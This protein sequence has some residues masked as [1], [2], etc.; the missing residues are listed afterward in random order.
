M[1]KRMPEQTLLNLLEERTRYLSLLKEVYLKKQHF[2]IEPD[3]IEMERLNELHEI[4]LK[5]MLHLEEKWHNYI[6]KLKLANNL[7]TET[8]DVILS[9]ILD[10]EMITRYFAYKDKMYQL[11]N[12]I[13]RIKKNSLLMSKNA[14]PFIEKK[15]RSHKSNFIRL[16]SHTAKPAAIED[17][18]QNHRYGKNKTHPFSRLSGNFPKNFRR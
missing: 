15:S 10:E 2:F 7:Q 6:K 9:M 8:T 5:E 3:K 16:S 18:S 14:F 12:E 4:F 13:D 17:H 1:E 11:L